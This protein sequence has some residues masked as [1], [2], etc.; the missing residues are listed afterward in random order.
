MQRELKKTKLSGR[1]GRPGGITWGSVKWY[2]AKDGSARSREML[3]YIDT[4]RRELG[5]RYYPAKEV[6]LT[7]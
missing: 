2:L 1:P 5:L 3:L 7:R 6:R 4:K